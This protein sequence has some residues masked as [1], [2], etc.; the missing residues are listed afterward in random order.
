M[1]LVLLGPPGAGKGTLAGLLKETLGVLHISTGDMLREEMN[2]QTA[3][4][5]QAKKYI[6]SGQLVP[7][8]I[9]VKLIQNKLKNQ[10]A[11]RKG[12][13]L[14]GFPRTESQA[15]QLDKILK[16]INEPL[17]YAFYLE[18]TLPVILQ[19]L[20]GRRVCRQCGALFHIKNRPPKKNDICDQC[21]GSLYQRA[22]DK[23]ETIKHV[24]KFTCKAQNPSLIIIRN[25]INLR[26]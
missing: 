26:N 13:L 17:D 23:E 3:L 24:W 20:T 8:E 11:D 14:D 15:K 18:A 21:G 19:R 4:G 2:R 10:K 25:R 6:E 22:D 7:D 9:V 5:L 1:N 12:Y 16:D